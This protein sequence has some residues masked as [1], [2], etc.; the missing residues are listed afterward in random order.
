MYIRLA[1]CPNFKKSYIWTNSNETY[2]QELGPNGNEYEK[3]NNMIIK[4]V[5][6]I[7]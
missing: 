7:K 2:H 6:T 5:T 1:P 4:S 3:T